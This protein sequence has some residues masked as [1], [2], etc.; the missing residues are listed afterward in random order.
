MK[1]KKSK[2]VNAYLK[3]SPKHVRGL[4]IAVREIILAAFPDIEETI[5][6]TVPFYTRKG[7]LCYISPLKTKD[8]I[9]IGFVKGYL[10]SDEHGIFTGKELKQIRHIEFRKESDIKKRLFKKYLEEAVMFNE[11]K[12]D[13]FIFE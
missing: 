10:M 8:G 6:F 13:A 4:M 5:K 3:H 1:S 11:L 7:L 2:E 12:K 9:Y